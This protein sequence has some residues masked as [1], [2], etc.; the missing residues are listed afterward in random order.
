MTPAQYE[1]LVADIAASIVARVDGAPAADITTGARSRVRG[2]SGFEHQIDV[3]VCGDC[4]S[5]LIE[6]KLWGDTVDVPRFLEFAARIHD[7]RS[8]TPDHPITAAVTTTVGFDPGIAPLATF[9]RINTHVVRSPNEFALLYKN[10][11]IISPAGSELEAQSGNPTTKQA[12]ILTP[13]GSE[14]QVQ[15]GTPTSLE[16]RPEVQ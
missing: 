13:Q 12:L 3:A 6:C 2:A 8:L 7:I 10:A 16:T 5:L 1:V 15:T 4:A 14:L 11:L 9:F